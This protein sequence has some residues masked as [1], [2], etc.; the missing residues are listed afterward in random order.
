[1]GLFH[2]VFPLAAIVLLCGCC[3]REGSALSKSKLSVHT[4]PFLSDDTTAFVQNGQPRVIKLFDSF[5]KQQ[6]QKDSKRARKG[7]HRRKRGRGEI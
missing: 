5:G 4:G 3:V 7:K 2:G 6:P 1:M